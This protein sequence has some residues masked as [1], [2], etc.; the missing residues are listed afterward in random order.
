MVVQ[1]AVAMDLVEQ[2]Q[3]VLPQDHLIKA[4]QA[5]QLVMETPVVMDLKVEFTTQVAAVVL[6]QLELQEYQV[7]Q[8]QVELV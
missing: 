2:H 7:A 3:M 8:V 1:A 5:E 4:T 6:E